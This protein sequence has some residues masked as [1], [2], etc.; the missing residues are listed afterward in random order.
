MEEREDP[1]SVRIKSA[2][3]QSGRTVVMRLLPG[4]ELCSGILQ[5]CRKHGIRG[6]II[7]GCFGSLGKI[8]LSYA[9]PPVPGKDPF[10][11]RDLIA[12][13]PLS[14]LSAQGMICTDEKGEL[15]IHLHGILHGDD[16]N[17]YGSHIPVGNNYVYNTV[18]V[19][20]M[21]VE[22]VRMGRTWDEETKHPEFDPQA[23]QSA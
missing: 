4:T 1:G 3:G 7:I 18:D 11:D 14:L 5:A 15:A 19:A 20:V 8:L 21:E 13:M 23:V 6:G 2:V 22:G 12:E 16:G 9:K 17:F 10:K